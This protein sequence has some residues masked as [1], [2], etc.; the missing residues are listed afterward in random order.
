MRNLLYMK[1]GKSQKA[2]P[3]GTFRTPVCRSTELVKSSCF[4]EFHFEFDVK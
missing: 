3:K 1:S 4:S 2:G